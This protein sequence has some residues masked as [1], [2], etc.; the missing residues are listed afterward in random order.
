M[1]KGIDFTC[2]Y[3]IYGCDC[4]IEF[5]FPGTIIPC[6]K[7]HQVT[8]ELQW[9]SVN[10][11]TLQPDGYPVPV[12]GSLLQSIGDHKHV[13]STINLCSS[14][15]QIELSD[16]SKTLPSFNTDSGYFQFKR[17]AMGLHNL[18]LSFQCLM[19]YVLSGLLGKFVFCFLDD[20][21]V[22]SSTVSDHLAT[23]ANVFSRLSEDGLKL[24]L[25]KCS[26]LKSN[27]IF[28]SP[29][30]KIHVV[31]NFSSQPTLTRFIASLSYLD[32]TITSFKV[33]IKLISH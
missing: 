28:E 19:N 10:S 13:F 3:N 24:E 1:N 11:I 4:T 29:C 5:T 9:N 25:S 14:F 23:H 8:G 15:W 2:V 18:L 33:T 16:K 30:D 22:A 32:S 21:I 7:V 17:M 31:N 12:L 20:I 6:A 27:K 26:F